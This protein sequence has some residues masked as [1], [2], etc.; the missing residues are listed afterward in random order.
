MSCWDLAGLLS[1]VR[2]SQKP[3]TLLKT[4]CV[5]GIIIPAEA[6]IQLRYGFDWIPAFAG[7]TKM[8]RF[9]TTTLEHFSSPPNSQ[10]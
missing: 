7:M 1:S 5:T 6:R 3:N 9:P 2:A 10:Q 4:L 8:G